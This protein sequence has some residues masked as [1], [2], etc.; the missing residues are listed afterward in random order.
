MTRYLRFLTALLPLGALLLFTGYSSGV[1]SNVGR[2][3]TGAPSSGGGM[4]SNCAS[5][6]NGG[7]YGEVGIEV[8]FSDDTSADTL[9]E[10]IPGQTYTV[11]VRLTTE[12]GSPAAYGFQAQFID[13]TTP[14]ASVAG[15]LS[16]PATGVTTAR[17]TNSGTGIVREYAEHSRPNRDNNEFTFDWTAPAEGTGP[18]TLYIVGNAVNGNGGTSGDNGSRGPRVIE[19]AEGVVSSLR[20]LTTTLPG[21]I[22]PNPSAGPTVLRLDVPTAN[23]YTLTISDPAGRQL[24][25][26]TSH[27][28]AGPQELPLDVAALPRGTYVVSLRSET[29]FGRYRF[30]RQ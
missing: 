5:C 10:Y 25:H 28:P 9:S 29:D 18:V 27:L 14:I 13:G 26:S 12:M 15:S 11:S 7:D 30:V 16:N 17:L 4:E 23:R 1:A 2:G 24:F 21:A 3:Y 20:N 22:V 6:H 8:S 19:L